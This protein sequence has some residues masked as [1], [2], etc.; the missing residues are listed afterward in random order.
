MDEALKLADKICIMQG[1]KIQQY[2]TAENLLKHP[3]SRTRNRQRTERAGAGNCFANH[4]RRQCLDWNECIRAVE[5][6]QF[7]VLLKYSD[8]SEIV[9]SCK[10]KYN[11]SRS[12]I[13][14]HKFL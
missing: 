7:H 4:S 2:D 1:G 8:I 12:L 14:F 11:S 13:H 6:T 10:C 9:L 3:D 5:N